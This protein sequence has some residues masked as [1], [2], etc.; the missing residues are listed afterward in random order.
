MG[1]RVTDVVS[2]A[3]L[4]GMMQ[5]NILSASTTTPAVEGTS[6]PASVAVAEV[7]T[8]SRVGRGIAGQN[9]YPV[10]PETDPELWE[11]N[12][13]IFNKAKEKGLDPFDV[14]FWVAKRELLLVAASRHGFPVNISHWK[15]GM[16]FYELEAGH[17]FGLQR[18]YEMIINS[19]PAHAYLLEGNNLYDQ[20]LVMC[21][22][23]GH[24][25]FFRNNI[26]FRNTNRN[27]LNRIAEHAAYQTK[28]LDE[29]VPFIEVE[30][31]LDRAYSIM[32]L[33]DTT[34]TSPRQL[35]YETLQAKEAER[36]PDDFGVIQAEDLPSHMKRR[37]NDPA[38]IQ[39]EREKEKKKL[40]DEAKRVPKHPDRDVLGFIIE[41]SRV[42]KPW[43][44]QM[45]M[46]IREQAYYL[47]PQALTKIMNEG[48]ASYW[49]MKLMSDPGIRDLRHVAQVAEHNSGTLAMSLGRIN[50]Y[51]VGKY[52]F[53]D[54]EERWDKGQHGSLWE[55]IEDREQRRKYDTKEMKGQEKIFEVRRYDNDAEFLRKY[56]TLDLAVDLKLFNWDKSEEEGHYYISSREFEEVKERL[57]GL[58]EN[59]G[60]PII[61][62]HD[63]NH[64][65]KGE[66]LLQHVYA[67]ELKRDYVNET[68]KNILAMW[69]RPVHLNTMMTLDS[70]EDPTPIR[71]T[72]KPIKFVDK[73]TEKPGVQINWHKLVKHKD[74][75]GVERWYPETEAIHEEKE[76]L[77]E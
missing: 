73:K 27:M 67:Y 50:P 3:A 55:M 62:V 18:I 57:I 44:R 26:W 65:D 54:I 20:K 32:D 16:E 63:G 12:V 51:T 21:H 45:L 38:R 75:D 41:N 5:S 34:N 30:R 68:L 46:H 37:I 11:W 40:E 31:F 28:I 24:S 7:D 72:V 1:L 58:I 76:E 64:D 77:K 60:E 47:A 6:N 8:S 49:H 13:K 42:L 56:L 71:V 23:M 48:W 10:S 15:N 39:E 52:I 17:K 14:V 33:I 66:L 25:D 74:K 4:R 61:E 43:Q 53:L 22:C 9:S 35:N 36:V 70:E 29:G 59:G 2:K 69:G 19:D